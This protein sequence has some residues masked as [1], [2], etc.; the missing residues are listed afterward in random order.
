MS[1]QT[2]IFAGTGAD[3]ED[4]ARLMEQTLGR[5][6]VREEGSD[7]YIR[8]GTAAVYLGPHDFDDN[9]IAGPGGDGVPLA[10]SYPA[11]IE[12]R[13][14]SGDLRRQQEIASEIFASMQTA[15]RWPAIYVDDMQK[16]IDSYTPGT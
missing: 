3:D 8:I 11:L 6:F 10:T 16:V 1:R 9:D 7:P 13:D 15:G 2:F 14:T 12:I 4:L 5:E